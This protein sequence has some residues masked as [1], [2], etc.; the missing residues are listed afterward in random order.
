MNELETS[1]LIMN[2]THVAKGVLNFVLQNYTR[3][4]CWMTR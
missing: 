1:E 2:Q 3:S 4:I